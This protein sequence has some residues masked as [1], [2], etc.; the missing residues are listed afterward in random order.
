MRQHGL[1]DIDIKILSY[2]EKDALIPYRKVARALGI[3]EGTVHNRIKR[4]KKRGV[5]KAFYTKLDHTLL[6]FDLTAVIGIRVSK[7][8]LVEVEQMLARRK[9]VLCVYDVTGE[10]DAVVVAR[11]RNRDELNR[12]IKNV[13]SYPNVERTVTHVVLNI[14]KEEFAIL[15]T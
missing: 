13:L 11:F 3:S 1:D 6:G 5:I 8:R 4:L 12:F 9:E 7:G 10:Y 14:V 15:S 2:L